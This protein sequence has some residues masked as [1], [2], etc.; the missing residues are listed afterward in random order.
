MHRFLNINHVS[1]LIEHQSSINHNSNRF[2]AADH[3]TKSVQMNTLRTW[4]RCC[5][6]VQDVHTRWPSFR[7]AGVHENHFRTASLQ[8]VQ[9]MITTSTCSC[10]LYD[11]F[12][13]HLQRKHWFTQT[14]KPCLHQTQLLGSHHTSTRPLPILRTKH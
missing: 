7:L 13:F 14:S 2:T 8:R 5:P 12:T 1:S 4:Q 6:K 3:N 9:I 11:V 10:S